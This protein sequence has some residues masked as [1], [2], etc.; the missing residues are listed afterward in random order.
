MDWRRYDASMDWNAP[1]MLFLRGDDPSIQ[2]LAIENQF[3]E[4]VATFAV[5]HIFPPSPSPLNTLILYLR[6]LEAN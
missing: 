2:I 1:E 3:T 6:P 5:L 4:K